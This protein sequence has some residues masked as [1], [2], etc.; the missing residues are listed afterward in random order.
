MREARYL[1]RL[2]DACPTQDPGA[3]GRVE[4]LLDHHGVRPLVAVVPDNR[5]P[6]L[7]RAP[8]DPGFWPRAQSW[9]DRGWALALHGCHHEFTGTDGG[10]VPLNRYTEFAGR[11]E[12]EQRAKIRDGWA[13][14]KAEGLQPRYWVAPA[15]SFDQTTLRVL[16]DET[17]I[18]RVSDGLSWRP[19]VRFGFAWYPQQ[20]WRPRACPPGLWTLCLHPNTLDDALFHALGAFL[21]RHR[22]QVLDWHQVEEPRRA[23]SARDL[24]WE[25]AY[26]AARALRRRTKP[27]QGVTV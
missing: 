12:A 24:A 6:D 19:F 7:A 14:L 3:W 11:P 27:A 17:S 5:D 15:H 20:L 22:S 16:A 2:D 18:R 23:W 13:R 9:A 21:D 4:A 25:G 10:L 8:V 26:R 1:I